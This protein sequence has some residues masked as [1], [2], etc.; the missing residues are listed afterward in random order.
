MER[1]VH[2]L[3]L[4]SSA[5]IGT[6]TSS[7]PHDFIVQLP[8]ALSLD[9]IG[10]WFC[11]LK[12]CYLG[13]NWS[14]PLYLCCSLCSETIAGDRKLPVLR[15]I[16]KKEVVIYDDCLYLPIRVRDID[17]LQIYFLRTKDYLPPSY[18]GVRHRE[19][20]A[21]HLTLELRRIHSGENEALSFR[22]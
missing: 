10:E 9:P 21:T 14:Y 5:G 13:F 6:S 18:S 22:T 3:H 15:V 11:C 8:E 7:S 1:S 16:H 19:P 4:N 12:Q 20:V 2:I 17:Q